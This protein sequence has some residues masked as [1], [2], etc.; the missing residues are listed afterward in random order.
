MPS[1]TST[2]CIPL[3]RV[4]MTADHFGHQVPLMGLSR[5]SHTSESGEMVTPTSMAMFIG[6]STC[7]ITLT[8]R[9]RILLLVLTLWIVPI[10][11]LRTVR[12]SLLCPTHDS[13]A[14]M[15]TNHSH[16]SSRGKMSPFL[17]TGRL[18][19]HSCCTD[20]TTLTEPPKTRTRSRF[21]GIHLKPYT[22]KP[23]QP[24][25]LNLSSIISSTIMAVAQHLI[26]R[27]SIHSFI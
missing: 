19:R 2:L 14:S 8:S 18:I 10:A 1:C 26:K 27:N 13:Q 24:F 7:H 20:N 9:G 25:L 23:A 11:M 4:W 21:V 3:L 16:R 5:K 22:C 17:P 15:D 12:M 6:T